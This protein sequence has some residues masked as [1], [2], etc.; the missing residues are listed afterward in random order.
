MTTATLPAVLTLDLVERIVGKMS[1][2]QRAN[3]TSVVVALNGYGPKVGLD[4]PHRLAQYLAQILHESGAFRYDHELWGPTPAQKRYEGRKDLG[5]VRKGD[6]SRYRGRGPL[7]IT[8]RSNY[9]AFS[10]W[11]KK[12]DPTAPN[13]EKNPDA[14]LTDPWEG[15]GPIW[16]WDSHGLN[17][18]ADDNNIEMI[19][20]R[21][22]GGLNGYADRLHWYVRAALVLLGYAPASVR[23]FQAEHPDAGQADGIAGEK[24][25]MALHRA[26]EGANPY[27]ETVERKVDKP[28]VP[29]SV[30]GEVKKKTG[31]WGWLTGILGTGGLGLGW[32][33]GM[34]WQAIVAIG[35]VLI[36]MLVVLLVLRKQLVGAVQDIRAAVEG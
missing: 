16:Y 13:F 31:L 15:L 19:T 8:G 7:Q 17:R 12:I 33:S 9:R 14:V 28:V 20:R 35:G 30:E 2:K 29:E 24:T 36:V 11:A 18:Y 21:I 25:R 10:A 22:N 34:D 23:Q 27:R 1:R 3:A 4:R 6:G 26:L 5:N 32:L